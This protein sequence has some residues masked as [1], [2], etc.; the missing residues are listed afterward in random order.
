[1]NSDSSQ[2]P[3]TRAPKKCVGLHSGIS[4]YSRTV[5]GNIK[6]KCFSHKT[7]KVFMFTVQV[8]PQVMAYLVRKK[9]GTRVRGTLLQPNSIHIEGYTVM[10]TYDVTTFQNLGLQIGL[11]KP[12]PIGNL[13]ISHHCAC[14]IFLDAR[15]VEFFA[16]QV[17][18]TKFIF[19][20]YHTAPHRKFIPNLKSSKMG[21]NVSVYKVFI[22]IVHL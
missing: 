19:S 1:M 8:Q 17:S 20:V 13:T 10:D 2:Y 14:T 6:S 18:V 7:Q 21:G 4:Y 11:V 12:P 5:A 3:L 16:V 9:L 15:F 22:N